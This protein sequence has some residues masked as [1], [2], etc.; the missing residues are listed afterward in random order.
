MP[1]SADGDP[2]ARAEAYLGQLRAALAHMEQS[3]GE[4]MGMLYHVDVFLA[5]PTQAGI[6]AKDPKTALEHVS[7]SFHVGWSAGGSGACVVACRG[8]ARV[9]STRQRLWQGHQCRS[10]HLSLRH[11]TQMYQSE[12]LNKRESLADLTC[13][14]ISPS[15][16]AE[17]WRNM[18]QVQAGQQ[19]TMD[20]LADLLAGL[21]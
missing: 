2:E 6:S 13:E 9:K 18:E 20:D 15:T 3:V 17:Q 16:F 10:P 1:S 7:D 21:G 8:A 11:T 4:M 19:Q 5:A 12:L 14:E